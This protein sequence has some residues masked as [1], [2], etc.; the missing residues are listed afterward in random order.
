MFIH[1][2]VSQVFERGT[3]E[4]LA[5]SH[6]ALPLATSEPLRATDWLKGADLVIADPHLSA[7]RRPFRPPLPQLLPLHRPDQLLTATAAV[8]HADDVAYVV[9]GRDVEVSRPSDGRADSAGLVAQADWCPVQP[10]WVGFGSEHG[11]LIAGC[12][13]AAIW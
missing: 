5:L 9:K 11:D 8:G 6:Q 3:Q 13:S 1:P 2:V 10:T 12:F 7:H 4:D